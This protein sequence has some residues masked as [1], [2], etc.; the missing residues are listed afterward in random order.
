MIQIIETNL[1][2]DDKLNNF[3]S[4]LIEVESWD[5]VIKQFISKD[6]K[7]LKVHCDIHNRYVGEIVPRAVKIENLKYND[8]RLTCDVIRFDGKR[9]KKL[10]ELFYQG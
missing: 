7:N 4:R 9:I 1:M 2:I 8:Y 6:V 5:Y 10:I 3:Q